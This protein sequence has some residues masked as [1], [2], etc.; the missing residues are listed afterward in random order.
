ML[1]LLFYY[2][3]TDQASSHYFYNS[4]NNRVYT[5]DVLN[6]PKGYR[7]IQPPKILSLKKEKFTKG[8]FCQDMGFTCAKPFTYSS[9]F[10]FEC[11]DDSN[12][13][14]SYICCPQ[15][16]FLHKVCTV[17]KPR[18]SA[19]TKQQPSRVYKC[20]EWPYV[21]SKKFPLQVTQR[22][23][24]TDDEHCPEG[25]MCC[26]QRCFSHKVCSR[27][28]MS[29][30]IAET[31]TTFQPVATVTRAAKGDLVASREAVKDEALKKESWMDNYI[32]RNTNPPVEAT[33]ID[34]TSTNPPVEATTIDSN[35]IDPNY[36]EYYD[37]QSDYDDKEEEEDSTDSN[38]RLYLLEADDAKA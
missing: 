23:K 26:P 33:T 30:E 34:S 18:R 21:C 32:K 8:L 22:F 35:A 9:T 38:L 19:D 2:L 1:K 5:S 6:V 28:V 16:C 14:V 10:Q 13:P 7:I 29:G 12:C 4:D 15:R 11:L 31:T 17:G 3:L 36:Q 27:T 24:C 25:L 37:E 20:A